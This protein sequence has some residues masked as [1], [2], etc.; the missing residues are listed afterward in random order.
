MKSI[1][2]I[3]NVLID[4]NRASLEIMIGVQNIA[5]RSYARVNQEQEYWFNAQSSI[6][7]DIIQQGLDILRNQLA[8]HQV[9][10]LDGQPFPWSEV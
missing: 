6:R 7:G 4:G 3:Q 10:K 2:W 5:D 9:T 1:R 8:N